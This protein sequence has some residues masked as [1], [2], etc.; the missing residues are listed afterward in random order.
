MFYE[1]GS[2]P[3]T[4]SNKLSLEL[5]LLFWGLLV[6]ISKIFVLF[7]EYSL[8]NKFGEFYVKTR[9]EFTNLP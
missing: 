8:K 3:Q 4:I 9:T 1:R 2:E 6:C 5:I 7:S